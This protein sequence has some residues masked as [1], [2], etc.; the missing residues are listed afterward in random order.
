VAFIASALMTCTSLVT[1]YSSAPALF[2]LRAPGTA[3][4]ACRVRPPRA[5][6]G[7]AVG[8][9]AAL[10]MTAEQD[11]QLEAQDRQLA[12]QDRQL[13][14]HE[15]LITE[16]QQ[17]VA[18]QHRT[19]AGLERRAQARTKVFTWTEHSWDTPG[20]GTKSRPFFFADGVR[21]ACSASCNPPGS[22]STHSMDFRLDEGPACTMHFKCSILDTDE[23]VIRVVS[24][25]E[26]GDFH[27]PPTG[28][29][30]ALCV[31]FNV[32]KGD[33]SR[34][35]LQAVA[36]RDI[37]DVVSGAGVA[38]LKSP[39]AG[40]G[41]S[42]R[43]P[44]AEARLSPRPQPVRRMGSNARQPGSFPVGHTFLRFRMV[45]HLYLPE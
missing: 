14:A 4:E 7:A 38:A 28:P 9:L 26:C 36:G 12:A 34:I 3:S 5:L 43:D 30:S 33:K 29:V 18:H 6:R 41:L 25:P 8:G 39:P 17:M 44:A 1:G 37:L 40:R 31:P 16:L 11:R 19:I 27:Q 24:P 45:V 35:P 20:R 15:T 10:S 42:P 22:T 23:G 32:T 21:G 13:A 2:S